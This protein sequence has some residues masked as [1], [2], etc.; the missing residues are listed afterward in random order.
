M[1]DFTCSGTVFACVP[2]SA[3]VFLER[4]AVVT[5][6]SA[7]E[8]TL[9]SLVNHERTGVPAGAGTNTSRGFDLVRQC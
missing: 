5:A 8:E 7:G 6:V 2:F 4:R 9:Q 1:S 3:T